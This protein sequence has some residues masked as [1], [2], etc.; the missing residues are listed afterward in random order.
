MTCIWGGSDAPGAS[1]GRD[2]AFFDKH[3]VP[4]P[5]APVE[6]RRGDFSEVALGFDREMAA[7]EAERCLRCDLRLRMSPVMLPPD[8]WL[9]F[10]PQNV[11][12]APETDGVFRLFDSGKEVVFIGSGQSIRE[13]LEEILGSGDEWVEK[14][15][16]LH[17]EETLMYTMRESELLQQFLQEHGRLPE[18]NDE[19]F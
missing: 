3:R 17:C 8:E 4:M 13:G 12:G 9:E 10:N 16:Y 6:Q 1:L 5:C 18:G 19:L 14:A 7:A 2:E 11:S 15:R